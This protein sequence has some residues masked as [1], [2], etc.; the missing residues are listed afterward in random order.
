MSHEGIAA[1][2]CV[3]FELRQLAYARSDAGGKITIGHEA[4]LGADG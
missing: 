1:R 2:E 4:Y 3:P